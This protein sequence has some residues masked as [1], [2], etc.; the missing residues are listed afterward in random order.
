MSGWK[1]PYQRNFLARKMA[2]LNGP[3]SSQPCTV[4]WLVEGKILVNLIESS[5]NHHGFIIS[6]WWFQHLWKIWLRQLG[7]WHIFPSHLEKY[8]SHVPVTTNQPWNHHGSIVFWDNFW[9]RSPIGPTHRF[10]ERSR[11]PARHQEAEAV[12]S[13]K[14]DSKHDILVYLMYCMYI[15][16]I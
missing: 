13:N 11:A 14:R 9:W 4:W 6:G 16:I 15:Y 1:I 8:S 3:F 7:W 10:S 12:A 5:W 2:D